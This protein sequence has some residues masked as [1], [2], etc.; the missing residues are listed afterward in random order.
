[1]RGE[2]WNVVH[3]I[4]SP[5]FHGT[6]SLLPRPS[7]AAHLHFLFIAYCIFFPFCIVRFGVWCHVAFGGGACLALSS[8]LSIGC[9]SSRFS[10]SKHIPPQLSVLRLL[11]TIF[12]Q[13]HLSSLTSSPLSH[14]SILRHPLLLLSFNE[15]PL[16]FC[17]PFVRWEVGCAATTP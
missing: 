2:V 1:M 16:F 8:C 14:S 7:L 17:V 9:I 15:V 6:H 12:I 5:P 10:R 4:D 13:R 11:P 3:I